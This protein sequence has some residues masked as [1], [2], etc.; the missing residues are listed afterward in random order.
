MNFSSI[1]TSNGA[2]LLAGCVGAAALLW[3][4]RRLTNQPA[5][6]TRMG[7]PRAL[8]A[9]DTVIGWPP[10]ATRVLTL[11]HQRA[12]EL[13]RRATP[14]HM[15][16][17]QVPLSH[18]I[19]V[20]TRH[21][22]VEWLRR[23]GHVC[24]DLMVCDAASNVV[25]IIEVRQADKV[26]SERARKRQQRI[27]RVLRA[28]GIP[29]HVWNEAFLPDPIAVRKALLQESGDTAPTPAMQDNGPDTAPLDVAPRSGARVRPFDGHDLPGYKE[30]PRSTWFDEL[31]A[32]QPV[33]LD[34]VDVSLD[35]PMSGIGRSPNRT[36]TAPR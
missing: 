2:L 6:P 18:F 12:L 25:A 16:L 17:A 10:E 13:L 32:T 22:Y 23:V 20:P 11:R 9:V 28:A 36:V 27:E 30:P 21:S 24:V 3:L 34:G 4:W 7:R 5:D 33:Q 15:I 26:D 19:K 31:N 29:L 14:E 35:V 8:D 1:A